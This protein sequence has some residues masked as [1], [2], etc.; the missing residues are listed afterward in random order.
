MAS[1]QSIANEDRQFMDLVKPTTTLSGRLRYNRILADASY[2]QSLQAAAIGSYKEAAQLAKQC[3]M[4]NRRIWAALESRSRIVKTTPADEGGSEVDGSIK[5]AFDPLSSMR[6]DQGVPL[7]M[8]VTHEALSGSDFWS[9]VPA[10]YRGLMQHSQIFAHQGLLHEAIFVAEQAE[11]I[12][13]AAKSPTLMID[14]SSWRAD[15]WAQSGRCDK[16]ESILAAFAQVASRK[17]L[18]TVGYQ[19]ALARVHHYSG[20]YE[21]EAKSYEVVGKLLGDLA[22][23]TYVNSLESFLP[24]VDALAEQMN[25]MVLETP[26]EQPAKRATASK[27]RKPTTKPAP[28][29]TAKSAPVSRTKPNPITSTR[30]GPKGKQRSTSPALPEISG[31]ANQ[32]HLLRVL[33]TSIMDRSILAS[34]LQD[35]LNA[36]TALLA[37]AEEMRDER[38]R[39]VAHMWATFKVRLAQ[40]SK[41]IAEDFTVNTLPESTI[42]FPAIGLGE[43]SLSGGAVVRR[44]APAPAATNKSVRA[45]KQPKESFIE[46]LRDARERLVEAHA[47]CAANGSNYV[48]H[49]VSAAL[50]QVTIL[51]SAVTGAELHSSLH[52]LYAAY[53]SGTYND[54]LTGSS[55]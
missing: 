27:A 32:C 49:Q 24:P 1:A 14:N 10:L 43:Q 45:K 17:C 3:V 13:S 46:T 9:L 55:S 40:S 44:A 52:P 30:R 33:Q 12:A 8:S 22:S 15:C 29:A 35:D 42:A 21:E 38:G 5:A 11:K 53:M 41:Q 25:N 50:G 37:R 39:E 26:R 16:A 19:S 51:L 7:V 4:L 20:R 48:F 36:A 2:V 18:S 23:P 47:L 31:V 28:R 6:N 54:S 34:I